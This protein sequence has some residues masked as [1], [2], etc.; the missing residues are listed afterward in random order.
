MTEPSDVAAPTK[1]LVIACDGGGIRGLITALLLAELESKHSSFLDGVYLHAGTSTGGIISLGL[2][3]GISPSAFVDLYKKDGATIFTES[4]CRASASL[5]EPEPQALAQATTRLGWSIWSYIAYLVCPWYTNTGLS[6]AVSSTLGSKAQ[7]TLDSLVENG[8]GYVLVNTLQLQTSKNVWAPLQLTN[9]PNIPGGSGETVVLDAAMSTSAAPMYFP[10]YQ[11]PVYGYCAD[12]GLFA[13]NPGATAVAALLQSG[14]PLSSIW[15]LSL[16]TGNTQNCYSGYLIDQFGAGN[17]GP[18][19]WLVPFSQQAPN[20]GGF[21]PALPM[22]S[23]VFDATS[24]VDDWICGQL[25]GGRY[26]RANVP[27]TMPIT[28][29]DY[30]QAAITEMT[31]ATGSYIDSSAEWA[32]ICEWIDTNFRG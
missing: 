4:A 28:L 3:C 19:N 32:T 8:A 27:L 31:T 5:V 2:A 22:L 13:N 15:M 9:L 1:Y 10:P 30:S 6:G 26:Q 12:G 16:S 29:D 11:H 23:A 20:D 14:V 24:D 21:T 18:L 25:L 7:A 17:F